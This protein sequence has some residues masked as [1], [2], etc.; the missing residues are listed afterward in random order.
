MSK[1]ERNNKHES[2][3][4]IDLLT[5]DHSFSLPQAFPHPKTIDFYFQYFHF[6]PP[7]ESPARRAARM[8]GARRRRR[9][10]EAARRRRTERDPDSLHEGP[11]PAGIHAW[12]R[13]AAPSVSG[14]G[15]REGLCR[16]PR[17]R[18]SARSRTRTRTRTRRRRRRRAMDPAGGSQPR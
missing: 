3:T 9:H 17:D 10:I 1:Y 18:S 8:R 5:S 14:R 13:R 15:W 2:V 7:L 12:G 16:R 4:L 11:S 6:F